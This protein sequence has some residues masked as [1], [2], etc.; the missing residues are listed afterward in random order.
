MRE[1]THKCKS[2]QG[3]QIYDAAFAVETLQMLA[4]SFSGRLFFFFNS[5]FTD[6]EI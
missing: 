6:E 1:G 4:W 3:S 2:A 5:H